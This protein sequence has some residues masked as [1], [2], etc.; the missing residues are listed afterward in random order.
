M[1]DTGGEEG[2]EG[3][4]FT[5]PIAER[6]PT[7]LRISGEAVVVELIA[8]AADSQFHL[9]DERGFGDQEDNGTQGDEK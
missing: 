2:P 3:W 7:P 5:P 1:V 6:E 4:E 9:I 8:D